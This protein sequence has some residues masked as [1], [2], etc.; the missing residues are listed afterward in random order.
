MHLKCY[1]GDLV[2]LAISKTDAACPSSHGTREPDASP[3]R[4]WLGGFGFNT[5]PLSHYPTV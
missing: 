2:F 3:G 4:V 5:I 1:G